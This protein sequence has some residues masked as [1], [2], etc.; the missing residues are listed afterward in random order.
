MC[1][2]K[3]KIQQPISQQTNSFVPL[4]SSPLPVQ[5]TT[6]TSKVFLE[7]GKNIITEG[8]LPFSIRLVF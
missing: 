5:P 4:S 8:K 2:S 3:E 7:N 1:L 6:T